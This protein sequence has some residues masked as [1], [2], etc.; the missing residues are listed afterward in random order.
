MQIG[1]LGFGVVG[2]GVYELVRNRSD[3]HVAYVLC[4]QDHTLP[5]G[6]VTHDIRNILDDPEVDTVVEAM[7]SLHPA[8]EFVRDAIMAGK[9]V[10]TCNKALVAMYYDELLPLAQRKNVLFRCTGAVGGGIGWLS[11]LERA[12]RAQTICRVG[13]IMNGTCNYILDAMTRLGQDYGEALAQAQS[14]GYAE[15]DPATDVDGID[16]WH[17]LILSVNVAFG[18]SVD[19]DTV[20]VAGIRHLLAEDVERFSRHGLVCRLMTEASLENGVLNA[21][22][23]PTLCPLTS[24]EASVTTNFNLITFV[25]SVSDRMSFYGQGAGRYP[26]AYNVLQDC[27]DI[28]VGRGF[29]G[30]YGPRI[31]ADNGECRSFYLR[32]V[33]DWPEDRVETRWDDAVITVPV[34]VREMHAWYADRREGFLA[35]LPANF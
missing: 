9:N 5:D 24:P 14:L 18:V 35:A 33:P 12:R 26:T 15:A 31:R 34:P 20:P 30:T 21:W 23:Q 27:L 29:Y 6:N 3:L 13:G 16:A 1:L 28:Q 32:G 11:E 19:R 10:V 7:G 17:K 22:V 8:F 25:G 4:R 2:K